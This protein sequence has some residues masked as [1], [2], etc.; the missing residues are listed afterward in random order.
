MAEKRYYWMRLQEG[1]FNSKRIKKLR[2]IAGGDTFTIIYLKMQLLALRGEGIL[3]YTGLESTFAEELALDLDEDA[4]NVEVTLNYLLSCGLMETSD[5]KE[6]FLPYCASNI[7]SEGS[8]AKRMREHRER[9]TS[10]GDAPTV[11]LLSQCDETPSH[12][13]GEIEKEKDIEIEKEKDKKPAAPDVFFEFAKGNETL[14][15]ALK[16]FQKMR[17]KKKKPL[18]ERAKKLLC[19]SLEKLSSDPEIQARIVDQSTERCWD[20]FYELKET[21]MNPRGP[22]TRTSVDDTGEM[23]RRMVQRLMEKSHEVGD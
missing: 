23:E 4:D 5:E 11:T 13:Y 2:R 18:T 12:C 7:G 15:E 6:F 9:Q 10:L 8:S 14:L 3:E 1:F 20:G 16:E 17:T 22:V 21:K 19:T